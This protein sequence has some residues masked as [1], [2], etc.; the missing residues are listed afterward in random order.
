MI[1]RKIFP[2]WVFIL[3]VAFA[4]AT[5][6]LRLSLVRLTYSLDQLNRTIHE[7]QVQKELLS[8]KVSA[9]KSPKRLEKIAKNQMGWNPPNSDQIIY[10]RSTDGIPKRK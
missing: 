2:W 9:L 3:G 7:I 6:W 1:F 8:A 4:V 10:M 5:V